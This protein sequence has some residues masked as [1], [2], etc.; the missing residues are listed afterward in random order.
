M[1][2]SV[3]VLTLSFLHLCVAEVQL[4]KQAGEDDNVT[5]SS[6]NEP[7]LV[8]EPQ[9]IDL[10]GPVQEKRVAFGASLGNVGNTGPYNVAITLTYK[11][12]FTNTG[13]YNPAT[14]IFTAPVKGVYYF[15]F[16]GHN[17]ST[18]T[19][20]LRLMKNEY[21]VVMA[22]NHPAGNRHETATNGMILQLQVGDHV[23]P[24]VEN[25]SRKTEVRVIKDEDLSD[26]VEWIILSVWLGSRR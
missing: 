1:K 14:G 22:Y 11:K 6:S 17:Q 8:S 12:V 15:S 10:R 18:R 16:S 13:A 24:S 7:G 21:H 3:V 2:T 5:V 4:L 20:C 25:C 23:Y 9:N 19:M 26:C